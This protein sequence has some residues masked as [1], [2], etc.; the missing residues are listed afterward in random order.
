MQVLIAGVA[1]PAPELEI[2]VEDHVQWIFK[3]PNDTSLAYQTGITDTGNN[4][5]E[6]YLADFD[7]IML[8]KLSKE[9]KRKMTPYEKEMYKAKFIE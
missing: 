4:T 9:Q 8:Q 1:S 7:K 2:L 5:D 6:A 3:H